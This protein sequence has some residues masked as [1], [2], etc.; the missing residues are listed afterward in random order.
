MSRYFF[1]TLPALR[2]RRA[3]IVHALEDTQREIC[4]AQEEEATAQ[5]KLLRMRAIEAL[6]VDSLEDIDAAIQQKV[7]ADANP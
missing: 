6:A 7:E 1:W 3:I 4:L 2:E 5:S